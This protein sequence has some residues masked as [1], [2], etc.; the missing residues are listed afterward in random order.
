MTEQ[1]LLEAADAFERWETALADRVD[2]GGQAR[3]LR[4]RGRWRPRRMPPEPARRQ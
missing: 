3:S 2:P 1:E 4:G